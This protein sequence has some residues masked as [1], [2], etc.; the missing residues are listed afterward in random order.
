MPRADAAERDPAGDRSARRGGGEAVWPLAP[1]VRVVRP[2]DP[3]PRPWLRGHRGVDLAAA[4]AAPV[5][6]T[7]AGVVVYAGPVAGRGVVSVAHADGLR[8]TY[9]PVRPVV[10]VGATVVAGQPLATLEPGHRGCPERACLH[11]GL[12][13]GSHYLDPLLLFGLARS[14]LLP[15]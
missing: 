1:P 10:A 15:S 14:R 13:D 7:A 4:P 12:R 3:P 6:S 8:T 9:E 2:F 11:W 5:R